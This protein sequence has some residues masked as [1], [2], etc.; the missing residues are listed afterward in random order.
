MRL[1]RVLLPYVRWCILGAA[2]G[3]AVE[4]LA[5]SSNGE[6]Q[7]W[8]QFP[9]FIVLMVVWLVLFIFDLSDDDDD[10]RADDDDAGSE[11]GK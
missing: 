6:F 1:L 8:W 4:A 11:V 9:V 2:M 7:P 3:W 5:Y 10:A